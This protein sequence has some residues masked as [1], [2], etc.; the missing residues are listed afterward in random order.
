M[1]Q[2]YQNMKVTPRIYKVYH[3]YKLNHQNVLH[4]AGYHSLKPRLSSL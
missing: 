3:R 4:I 2:E 1:H